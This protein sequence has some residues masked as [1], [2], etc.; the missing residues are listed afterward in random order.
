ME[1][2]SLFNR[3]T[4]QSLDLLDLQHNL[5]KV[6]T[7]WVTMLVLILKLKSKYVESQYQILRVERCV[8][9]TVDITCSMKK[10]L[11]INVK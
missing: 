7:W 6:Y 5:M 4:I 2:Y 9:I 3:S 1:M 10:L 8:H 11:E